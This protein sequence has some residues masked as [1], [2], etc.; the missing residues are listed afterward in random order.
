MIS[1]QKVKNAYLKLKSQVYYDSGSLILRRRIAEFEG[2]GTQN[3]N[4]V[5]EKLAAFHAS[6][7][8]QKALD[9]YI[10]VLGHDIKTFSVPKTISAEPKT[11]VEGIMSNKRVAETYNVERASTF[12]D[13]PIEIHLLDILWL[14][15]IGISLEQQLKDTAF[16][17]RLRTKDGLVLEQSRS[18]FEPYVWQY[19]R[20]R[21]GGFTVAENLHVGNS[22]CLI[23]SLD[24][25]NYY[26]SVR[27]NYASLRTDVARSLKESDARILHHGFE[28]LHRLYTNRLIQNE[29]LSAG[30]ISPNEESI[31]PIGL[32]SSYVLGNW[33]LNKFDT[34]VEQKVRPAYYGRYVDDLLFVFKNSVPPTNTDPKPVSEIL[35]M[36]LGAVISIDQ[37]DDDA[38]WRINSAPGLH[39]GSE[40]THV[41]YFSHEGSAAVLE[42]I[43][44]D[45]QKQ[46]SEFRFLPD[47]DGDET[48]F[49]ESAYELHY[50]D[51]K[52]KPKT[53]KDYRENRYGLS[54]YL[55][56]RIATALHWRTQNEPGESKR[57]LKF[58]RG[59]SSLNYYSLWE[60][61]LTY[62][63][64]VKDADG[65]L[66]FISHCADQIGR[67]NQHGISDALVV[68]GLRESLQMSA[69]MAL[70]LEPSFA[71]VR[72]AKVKNALL[73]KGFATD[74]LED[75]VSNLRRANMIRHHYVTTPL[76][77]YC[78]ES[79]I[80][81]RSFIDSSSPPD[82]FLEEQVTAGQG[83]LNPSMIAF[84]PRNLKF[85][86]IALS[87]FLDRLASAKKP[88]CS[89]DGVLGDWTIPDSGGENGYLEKAFEIYYD[90]NFGAFYPHERGPS[91]LEIKN[92]LFRRQ[93]H[94]EAIRP[95][96]DEI[97]VCGN[98][99][100]VIR[101]ALANIKVDEA[102]NLK[103]LLGNPIVDPGRL[104]RLNKVL[105]ILERE[106]ADMLFL[107]EVSVPH[108]YLYSLTQY[109]GRRE[110][111]VVVGFEHWNVRDSIYNFIATLLPIMVNGVWDAIPVLRLKNHYSPQE[112]QEITGRK[113]EVPIVPRARYDLY[114]WRGLYFSVFYCFELANIEHRAI[115]RSKV[116]ML[117]CSEF[118]K[119]VNYYGHI[120]SATS[121]DLHC[122]VVQVNTAQYGDSRVTQPS[123]TETMNLLQL[124]GG[125]NST[126]LLTE[127]DLD[128]LREF[129]TKLYS[130][131]DKQGERFKPTPP[132]IDRECVKRRQQGGWVMPTEI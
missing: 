22:D 45:I 21:N 117:V 33:Y 126:A 76:I 78:R 56:K 131:Q 90:S 48:T 115:F 107:P 124:K 103:S 50:E 43:K 101:V 93:E 125:E 75:I 122:Y 23:I 73:L 121:R 13:A 6:L 11:N 17:N 111:A 49:D 51:S 94:R 118:N 96:I 130:L 26:H 41:M 83:Y 35:A 123:S 119:D 97:H 28:A 30:S 52:G 65:F 15:Y 120:V 10:E 54:V 9:N 77:N 63:L 84:S 42:K 18:L 2:R 114:R 55:A 113:Y 14:L 12:I 3:V 27:L 74:E 95:M 34:E 20:W 25:K 7:R 70:A 31:L 127:I 16:G 46:S 53:L 128:N 19:S 132:D 60:K 100:G 99:K 29:V 106:N 64:V 47:D 89:R 36:C 110:T 92:S 105:N 129:Q 81:G 79:I 85:Y 44:K 24:I 62:F 8:S 98:P 104:L 57:I 40:K 72:I 82:A 67:I 91:M 102:E 61:I 4:A 108:S 39:L 66:E 5:E 86:E 32:Y 68:N 112:E 69:S 59:V 116:D 109:A 71:E 1:L 37:H 38:N 88:E 58:F 87:C 80:D